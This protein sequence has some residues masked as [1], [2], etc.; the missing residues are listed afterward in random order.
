MRYAKDIVLKIN[1]QVDAG[2][3]E[4][5]FVPYLYIDYRERSRNYIEQNA[6]TTVS[7][8]SENLMPT[9]GFWKGAKVCFFVLIGIFVV[10]LI[11]LTALQ[12]CRG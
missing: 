2:H 5:I 1:L 8:S 3:E 4:M 7:F 6:L 10:L 11:V 9:D 12:T